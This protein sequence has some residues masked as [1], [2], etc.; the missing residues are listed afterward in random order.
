MSLSPS[1]RGEHIGLLSWVRFPVVRLR[2]A[3]SPETPP[4][5]HPPIR[6]RASVS[7]GFVRVSAEFSVA[8]SLAHHT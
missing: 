8:F 5:M 4:A 2:P 7:D 6:T 1:Y 3:L